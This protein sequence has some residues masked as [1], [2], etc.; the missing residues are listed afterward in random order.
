MGVPA[1]PPPQFL[2]FWDFGV[3]A[4]LS[5]LGRCIAARQNAGDH[6]GPVTDGHPLG[7]LKRCP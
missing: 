1:R 6:T 7:F 4:R 2:G 3:P 5:R